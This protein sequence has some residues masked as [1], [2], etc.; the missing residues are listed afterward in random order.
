ME[1]ELSVSPTLNND[2]YCPLFW[3]SLALNATGAIKPCCRFMEDP[4]APQSLKPGDLEAAL[5]SSSFIAARQAVSE[6]LK[7]LACKRCHN[8]ESSGIRSLRQTRLNPKAKTFHGLETSLQQI[9]FVEI[10]LGRECNLACHSCKPSLSTRWG[11]EFKKMGLPLETYKSFDYEEL[12]LSSFESLKEVKFVGGET[13]INDQ[14]L[15]VLATIP[16]E[17]RRNLNIEYYTNATRPIPQTWFDF[18]SDFKRVTIRFSIDGYGALN[19]YIRYPSQ[20]SVIQENINNAVSK[21]REKIEFR[22]QTT[23]SVYNVFKYKEIVNWWEQVI[24]TATNSIQPVKLNLL[25]EPSFMSLPVLKLAPKLLE[26]IEMPAEWLRF[27][28]NAEANPA[29]VERLKN[30]T[31]SLDKHRQLQVGRFVPELLDLFSEAKVM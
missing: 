7:V 19:E 16:I 4:P 26:T 3:N 30:Y 10:F 25:D 8:E 29:Q 9:E 5:H 20:W 2:K 1:R 23:V 24:S 21:K 17:Q 15:K 22:V 27:I 28:K 31:E 18:W 6:G 13:F 12:N 11:A 14:H